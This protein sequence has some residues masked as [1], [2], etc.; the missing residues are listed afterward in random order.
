ME[1]FYYKAKNGKGFM[2]LKTPF[3]SEDYEQITKEEFEELTQ[4]KEAAS[5]KKAAPKKKSTSKKK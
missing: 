4:P 2:N 1:R 3:V 5:E